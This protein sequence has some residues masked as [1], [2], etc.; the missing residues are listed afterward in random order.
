MSFFT[1]FDKLDFVSDLVI[2]IRNLTHCNSVQSTEQSGMHNWSSRRI[3]TDH[4]NPILSILPCDIRRKLTMFTEQSAA[5]LECV[6][7]N[8]PVTKWN[9]LQILNESQPGQ[10]TDKNSETELGF[11]KLFNNE[12]DTD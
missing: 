7:Y 10:M 9:I 11:Q 12:K 5:L 4:A 1:F 2:G 6:I 8:I 3:A